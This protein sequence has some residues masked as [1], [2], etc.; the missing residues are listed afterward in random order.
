MA[1]SKFAYNR[2][3][4]QEQFSIAYLSSLCSV[5]G[6][7]IERID[8][9]D[10]KSIDVQIEQMCPTAY[11]SPLIDALKV[12]IKCKSGV[13]PNRNGMLHI[14]LSPKNYNDLRVETAIPRILVLLCIPKV[15]ES[16]WLSYGTDSIGLHN[17]AYWY[18]LRGL[19]EHI[20][21]TPMPVDP[22]VPIDIPAT[23]KLTS[24][25]LVGLMDKLANGVYP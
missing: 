12:Q 13:K 17:S 21:P 4:R 3:K 14:R 20:F 7:T 6:F 18:S 22:K 10:Q 24:D 11:G 1:L 19:P 8:S 5:S 15:D 9:I 16:T 23:Q 2:S 25:S